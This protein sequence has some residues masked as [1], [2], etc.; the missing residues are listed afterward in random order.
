[1]RKGTARV[2]AFPCRNRIVGY[3]RRAEEMDASERGVEGRT[4][5]EAGDVY[6]EE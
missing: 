3:S 6:D 5:G 2:A 1:M 4:L